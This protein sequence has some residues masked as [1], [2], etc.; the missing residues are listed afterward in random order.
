MTATS[1][2]ALPVEGTPVPAHD[3]W[4]VRLPVRAEEITISKETVVRERVVVKRNQVQDVAQVSALLRQEQLRVTT[5]EGREVDN[6]RT[7]KLRGT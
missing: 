4:S 5:S 3:T 7:E 1:R 2:D 6:E